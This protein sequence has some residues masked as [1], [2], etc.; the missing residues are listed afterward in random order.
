MTSPSKRL[1]PLS[2]RLNDEERARLQRN[3]GDLPLSTYAKSVLFSDDVRT[4]R[5]SPRVVTGD[6][7]ILAKMLAQLGQ[8]EVATSLYSLAR[9]AQ[10]GNLVMDTA[11]QSNLFQACSDLKQMRDVLLAS[12]GK[13]G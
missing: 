7:Q 12:L 9:E 8:S 13:R 5:R 10:A 1:P 2:I 6:R 3:A 11:S 4:V